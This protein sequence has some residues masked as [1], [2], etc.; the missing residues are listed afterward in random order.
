MNRLKA[1]PE[2]SRA[3]LSTCARS[4]AAAA[5]LSPSDLYIQDGKK[6]KKKKEKEKKKK[7]KKKKN[8]GETGVLK[9]G[10][11]GCFLFYFQTVHHSNGVAS[12]Q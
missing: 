1:S 10:D 11:R 9:K 3:S 12:C 8:H 2:A 6:K 4:A 5:V 7:K